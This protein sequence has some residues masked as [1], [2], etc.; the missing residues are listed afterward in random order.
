MHHIH[1]AA[2]THESCPDEDVIIMSWR[3]EEGAIAAS[4]QGKMSILCPHEHFYLD[5]PNSENDIL[6]GADWMPTLPI[7]KISSYDIPDLDGIIG[8]QCNLWTEQVFT[9]DDAR[10]RLLP[11]LDAVA[12]KCFEKPT[13]EP[14]ITA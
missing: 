3:G 13:K 11:R 14:A 4:K 6:P 12:A 8:L 1:I 2:T 7:E 9:V 5:Y 10:H